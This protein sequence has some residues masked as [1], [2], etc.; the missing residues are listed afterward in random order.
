MEQNCKQFIEILMSKSEILRKVGADTYE[1]WKPEE[2]PVTVL[3][4]V[5]GAEIAR[6]FNMLSE[7]TKK[8]IFQH[9]EEGMATSDIFL[10]TAIATGLIEALVSKA[11]K[12]PKQLWDDIESKLGI[13]SKQY[14]KEWLEF[15]DNL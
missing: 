4:G 11:E 6:Q 9:I 12:Q 5:L 3:F 15:S 13:L 7:E 1:Y 2:P 8:A 10:T 14:V